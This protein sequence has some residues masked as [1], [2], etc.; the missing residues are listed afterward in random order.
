[1]T[2]VSCVS[3]DPPKKS[4]S[5]TPPDGTP[6]RAVVVRHSTGACACVCVR[7]WCGAVLTHG[8]PP[9]TAAARRRHG[10]VITSARDSGTQR[11]LVGHHG[12]GHGG[13]PGGARVGAAARDGAAGHGAAGCA[14]LPLAVTRFDVEGRAVPR[15]AVESHR[16]VRYWLPTSPPRYSAPTRCGHCSRWTATSCCAGCCLPWCR[17]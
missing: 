6:R 2:L 16:S 7:V 8:H 12:G 14:L 15:P 17:G 11:V 9:R 1:M 10:I 5:F 4:A 3:S 13:G